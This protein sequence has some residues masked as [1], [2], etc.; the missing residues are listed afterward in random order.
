MKV[1][2]F[3]IPEQNITRAFSDIFIPAKERDFDFAILSQQQIG[4][5]DR[6]KIEK[7]LLKNEVVSAAISVG[8]GCITGKGFVFSPKLPYVSEDGII[9]NV[10]HCREIGVV[11]RI[12]QVRVNS[13]FEDAGG[14][15]ATLLS[16]LE[17][18]VPYGE[19]YGYSIQDSSQST[20]KTPV[21][22]RFIKGLFNKV[23]YE[24]QKKYDRDT[25]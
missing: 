3:M 1:A 16:F 10:K 25:T 5:E 22:L 2:Y 12:K 24:I 9:V 15:H 4:I 17:A 20:H 11:E 6:K 8:V 7:L 18:V 23:N 21:P 13:H 19:L 14:I